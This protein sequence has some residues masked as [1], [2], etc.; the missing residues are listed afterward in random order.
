MCVGDFSRLKIE[1]SKC[2]G[3]IPRACRVYGNY[4][5][6]SKNLENAF[7]PR[8]RVGKSVCGIQTPSSKQ[9]CAPGVRVE[10]R[11]NSPCPLFPR[12]RFRFARLW[13]KSALFLRVWGENGRISG[14]KK[15]L[16]SRVCVGSAISTTVSVL[17]NVS[18]PCVQ[19]Q[20]VPRNRVKVDKSPGS[21]YLHFRA[22]GL[23]VGHF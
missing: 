10:D 18:F 21:A 5:S 14:L 12:V 19:P 13:S 9:T 11:E 16:H 20:P 1:P 2:T 23:L 22:C 15:G 8:V 7:S 4:V 17:E 3:P 6:V